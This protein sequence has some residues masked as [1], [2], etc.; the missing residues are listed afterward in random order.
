MQAIKPFDLS[1]LEEVVAIAHGHTRRAW[2]VTRTKG[3][4]LLIWAVSP[5]QA[6]IITTRT[7]PGAIIKSIRANH[8][9]QN[10]H[11]QPSDW[12]AYI[13]QGGES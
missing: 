1:E 9:A 3:G 11:P 12:V 6:A 4:P 8:H 5:R 2:T 10:M 13:A 7:Q